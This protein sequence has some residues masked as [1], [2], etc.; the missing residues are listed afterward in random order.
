[1]LFGFD[2]KEGSGDSVSNLQQ[3]FN[4]SSVLNFEN[5][6]QSLLEVDGETQGKRGE[7]EREYGS[8]PHDSSGKL[9]NVLEKLA[10]SIVE[11]R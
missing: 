3:Q 8:F 2:D 7:S 9:M 4:C 6:T 5:F 1:M 10:L 11:N